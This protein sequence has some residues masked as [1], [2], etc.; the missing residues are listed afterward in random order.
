MLQEVMK[1]IHKEKAQEFMGFYALR[2]RKHIVL[3]L[4][5]VQYSKSD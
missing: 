4:L 3:N 5:V 2:V 1:F